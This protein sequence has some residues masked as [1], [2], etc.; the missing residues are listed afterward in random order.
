MDYETKTSASVFN[1]SVTSSLTALANSLTLPPCF[2]VRMFVITK[3]SN[4]DTS[5]ASTQQHTL[6]RGEERHSPPTTTRWQY[7]TSHNHSHFAGP[8]AD[9]PRGP[10]AQENTTSWSNQGHADSIRQIR[11]EV[12]EPLSEDSEDSDAE[13]SEILSVLS[14]RMYERRNT[15]PLQRRA[16]SYH[17]QERNY[18]SQ[19]RSFRDELRSWEEEEEE[20][21]GESDD[22][23][24]DNGGREERRP[25]NHD[26]GR[27]HRE[28]Y[29]GGRR[30]RDQD[31]DSGSVE[32][33]ERQC[34]RSESVR[35]HDRSRHGNRDLARTWSC[36]ESPDKRVHFQDDGRGSNRQQDESS[37]VWEMLGQ[38]LRE[39]GVPVRIGGNGAPLQIRPQSRDSQVLHGSEVS[40]GDSQPHQRAF[41]RA[42]TSRHSFHG[43]IRERK[44]PSYRENSGRDHRED[45]DRRRDNVEHAR[46]VYEIS[47][48]DSHLANRAMGSRDSRRWREQRYANDDERE[49]TA[50]DH[51]VE[52]TTSKRRHGRNTVEQRLSSEEEQEVERRVERPPRRAPQR[53]QSLSSSSSRSSTRDRSRNMAAGNKHPELQPSPTCRGKASNT[54]CLHLLLSFSLQ[55]SS[56]LDKSGLWW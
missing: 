15:A 17:P 24:F 42:A 29:E 25:R 13:L 54:V 56:N 9:S 47:S 23:Y 50:C 18:T 8:W 14:Q 34:R 31:R 38:V 32:V 39:R 48:R 35:L 5:L 1:A 36:K 27:T 28:E 12:R 3:G 6:Q 55:S 20:E 52:R 10:A 53:S 37:H 44:R 4:S 26:E 43:D 21:R 33:R 51:R 11:S 45:R 30:S 7:S 49:R 41:Q 16:S 19:G 40:Y 22:D 46:E 2:C